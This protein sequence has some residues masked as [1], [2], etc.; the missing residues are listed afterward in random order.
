MDIQIITGNH[1]EGGER[2][3]DYVKGVVSDAL[4]RFSTQL[5]HVD[6]HFSD[7]NSS[8]VGTMDKRCLI[9]ARIAGR[10]NTVVT[11]DASTIEDSLMGAMDKMKNSIESTLGKANH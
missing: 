4:S 9:E 6:V 10:K 2:F 7:Q 3:S 11:N 5:T 1:I 8:K